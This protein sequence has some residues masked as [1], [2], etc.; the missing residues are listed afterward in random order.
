VTE[1]DDYEVK[2]KEMEV[3]MGQVQ[4]EVVALREEKRQMEALITEQRERLE[5]IDTLQ[6]KVRGLERENSEMKAAKLMTMFGGGVG[7][8]GAGGSAGALL[9]TLSQA[10]GGGAAGVNTQNSQIE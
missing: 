9:S 10:R 6:E 3:N 1:R 4:G 8:T 2:L 5:V 7:A